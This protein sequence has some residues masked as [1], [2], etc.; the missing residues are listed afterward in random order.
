VSK[1]ADDTEV[2]SFSRKVVCAKCGARTNYI[3]VRPNWIEQRA[4]N[5]RSVL[6]RPRARG[7]DQELENNILAFRKERNRKN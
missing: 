1:V 4:V 6:K 3:D 2:P 5:K 7:L